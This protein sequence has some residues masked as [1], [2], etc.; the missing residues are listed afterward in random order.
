M[1]LNIDDNNKVVGEIY[2]ITNITNDKSYIGQT[3]SHRL[4]R[5]K[6]R[7][8]GY[9][10]RFRDHISESKSNKKNCSRYLN[11]AFRKYGIHNF[12]CEIIDICQV[13][14]LDITEQKY[15]SEHNTK[16]PNG[17]NLTSGGKGFTDIDGKH[18]WKHEPSVS[19][20]KEPR[21]LSD[22]TKKLISCRL[23][24]A[25]NSTEHRQ[26]MMKNTQIQHFDR[27]FNLFKSVVII[28]K[29]IDNY[30][31]VINNHK[32]KTKYVRVVIDDKKTTFV[33][34]YETVDELKTRAKTFISNLIEWQRN[35]IAGNSLEPNTTT[36]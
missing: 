21:K 23:K 9:L 22:S 29:E 11:Y 17:Y 31:R 35:Q 16:Y 27:K 34:L 1:I 10:G 36:L 30:I 5:G 20:Y 32:Q 33:G 19:L 6:Y 8:F 13:E 24:T 26:K 14:E 3:R 12:S 7:P 2:K 28:E 25:L 15:I 18:I 4:N